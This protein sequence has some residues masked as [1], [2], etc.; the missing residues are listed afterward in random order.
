MNN[1]S[2]H[3]KMYIKC[4]AQNV[5]FQCKFNLQ[6]ICNN[7]DP[8]LNINQGRKWLPNTGWARLSFP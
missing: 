6:D 3:N 5:D 4:K 8:L 1:T 2:S 7:F